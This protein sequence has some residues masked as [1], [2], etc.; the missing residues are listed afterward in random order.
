MFLNDEAQISK[1]HFTIFSHQGLQVTMLSD[2]ISFH[3]QC[4]RSI[5]LITVHA[6]EGVRKA[7]HLFITNGSA[8]WGSHY[9]NNVEIPHKI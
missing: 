6:S 3:S 5:K 4:P 9:R 1:E 7:K 2:Y 8:N